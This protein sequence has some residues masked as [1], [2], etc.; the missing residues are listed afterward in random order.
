MSMPLEASFSEKR[1]VRL[2]PLQ[3]DLPSEGRDP[4]VV[5][6][7][8]RE[9]FPGHSYLLESADTNPAG[10]TGASPWGRYSYIG[11]RPLVT[12]RAFGDRMEVTTSADGRST[13]LC[14][15]PIE[16][17]RE[18]VA[19]Y[20]TVLQSSP[21]GPLAAGGM[22]GTCNYDLVRTWERLPAHAAFDPLVPEGV[23]IAAGGMVVFDHF[24]RRMRALAFVQEEPGGP[25][26]QSLEEAR[27]VLRSILDLLQ[28]GLDAGAT[29]GSLRVG[30]FS[31]HV[32]REEFMERVRLA[33]EKICAGDAI[34]IVLSQRF[35]AGIEGDPFPLYRALR[36]INPS[37]YMFYLDFGALQMVGASPEMLVRIQDGRLEV[38]PIAGTRPRGADTEEDGRLERELL[39]DPKERAEHVM[40]VDLGRND[41]GRVA[42]ARSV[43]VPMFMKVERY[44]HVMHLVSRVE[45]RLKSGRDCFDAFMSAFP[46]GT[47][48]GA[49][50]IRAMEIIQ[51]LEGTP[52]GPY[53]G[54]VGWFGFGGDADLCIT[55]RTLVATRGRLSIQA[56]AGIVADSNPAAE[57]E[58]T[59]KKAAALFRAVEEAMKDAGADR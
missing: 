34:Q 48:S 10:G 58:E 37:P 24:E 36:R 30:K 1:R 42:A 41:V 39:E 27:A 43:T 54:A 21:F 15:S 6:A 17:L 25:L 5:Y 33:Q 22:V 13:V 47:V 4:V 11:F 56:G 7:R 18:I 12:C 45:G 20:E 44:S 2:V 55:I 52:R 40:L 32:G 29:P 16:G 14:G 19:G 51:E 9:R 57:Y 31:S 46:A 8:I 38:C 28:D 50:K 23:F 53:A 35:S 3:V 26:L 59:L 49:P